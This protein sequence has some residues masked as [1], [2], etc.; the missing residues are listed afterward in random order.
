MTK[1]D[2]NILLSLKKGSHRAFEK[3]FTFY[4]SKVS[5]FILGYVKTLSDA[6]ELAQGIFVMLWQNHTN[7]NPEKSFDSYLYTI[8]KNKAL[9][10]LKRKYASKTIIEV[11][12]PTLLSHSPEEEYIALE[13]ALLIE[14]FVE[15]MPAQRRKIY[16]LR[17]TGF[18][19]EEIAEELGTTKRNV[20]SQA[21]L[22]LK[23][24][25]SAVK[26]YLIVFV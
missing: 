18:T 3:V 12:A 23:E 1:I 25:R 11:Q 6:K 5:T 15:K 16:Q 22:A 24:L 7:I 8:A 9:N 26:N 10:F 4:Y 13:N 20:E 19:N 2:Q 17:Q 14:M 21:S